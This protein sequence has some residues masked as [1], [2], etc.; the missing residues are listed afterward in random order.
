MPYQALYKTFTVIYASRNLNLEKSTLTYRFNLDS[1]VPIK[2][3][4]RPSNTG[5]SALFYKSNMH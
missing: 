2:D 4:L 1:A 5:D 3:L